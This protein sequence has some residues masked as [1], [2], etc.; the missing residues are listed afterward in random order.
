MPCRS[1][2][3]PSHMLLFEQRRIRHA[4]V[5]GR[6]VASMKAA[7]LS[8]PQ[9]SKPGQGA[10][11]QRR[12]SRETKLR[13]GVRPAGITHEVRRRMSRRGRRFA[14]MPPIVREETQ[15]SLV[16]V[17]IAG[18]LAASVALPTAA[19]GIPKA[20]SPEEVGSR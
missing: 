8:Q 3:P 15:M 18:V 6:A 9:G 12:A 13:A 16:R 17:V 1:R 19:Q 2:P 10:L 11:P 20:Q 14:L 5:T 7:M 4:F